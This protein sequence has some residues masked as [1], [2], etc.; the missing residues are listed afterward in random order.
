MRPQP[1]SR[2]NLKSLIRLAP[3]GALQCGHSLIAVEMTG[4]PHRGNAFGGASMRPQPD[5]RGNAAYLAAI[6]AAMAA[7]MRPQ[8]DS[9]GYVMDHLFR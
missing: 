5:S 6:Q 8:P 4:V 7:S 3:G 2:G 1:D 9:R